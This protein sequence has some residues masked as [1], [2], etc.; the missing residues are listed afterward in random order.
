[1]TISLT[2]EKAT[3]IAEHCKALVDLDRVK[4]RAVAQ[5]VGKIISSLPGVMYGALY[6][7]NIEL[8]KTRALRQNAGNFDAYM[9]LSDGAKKELNWWVR[10]AQV[11]YNLIS[12]GNPDKVLTTDASLTGWGAVFE[13][14]ST[15]GSWSTAEKTNNINALELLAV[16]F[17]LKCY[18][19][20]ANNIHIRIM[21]DNTT[22]VSTINH[23]GTCHSDICN[24][25]GKDIW[26]WCLARSI[27]ISA[28]H[29]PGK[30]NVQA[31]ME[32]RKIN[33]GAEWMLN[34]T[35]LQKSLTQLQFTPVIDLFASR[36][37]KQ[38]VRYASFRPDPEAE[39]IDAFTIQWGNLKFY[40]FSP[41]SVVPA[42]LRK[43]VEDQAMGVC[44]LPDWPTRAWTNLERHKISATAKDV[45]MA[46]WREST[47][48]QY[49]TYLTRW[50][51]FCAERNINWS[52][53]TVEQGIDFL[54]NLFE[55]KL[56]YSAINTARSALSVI[57]TPKDGTSFEK[58]D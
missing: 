53:A 43:I 18:A 35:D 33:S 5:V 29:I 41:F 27:W 56:S 10:N 12:H 34:P 57:L 50:E 19:K 40:M 21:T 9:T 14:E 28:A 32:S 23:M 20:N 3:A 58:T 8:D 11:S 51:Q 26:E 54:A 44:V 24:T 38:F 49:R 2:E 48:K 39:I 55:Q 31:D 4:I 15:G 47:K 30:M 1:M 25:I 6:H 22:A 45:I 7:R 36:I 46:S 13:N 52:N 16:F 17:G 37:N 42:V